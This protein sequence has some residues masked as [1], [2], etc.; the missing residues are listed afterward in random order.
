MISFYLVTHLLLPL[1]TRE[2]LRSVFCTV[3]SVLFTIVV[4]VLS[5]YMY[6]CRPARRY[7]DSI[8]RYGVDFVCM[9]EVDCH[10][11]LYAVYVTMSIMRSKI[12]TLFDIF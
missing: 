12:G 7:R 11:A 8:R 10:Y 2:T 6:V 1:Y 4:G 9:E 5:T 3:L